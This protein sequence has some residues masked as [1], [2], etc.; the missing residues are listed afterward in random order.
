MPIVYSQELEDGYWFVGKADDISD[1]LFEKNEWTKTHEILNTDKIWN[2]YTNI[3]AI[4]KFYMA[5]Y[6][7]ERV[8]GGSYSSAVLSPEEINK[9]KR[10]LFPSSH[11]CKVIINKNFKNV[12]RDY[13]GFIGMK[14][15]CYECGNTISCQFKV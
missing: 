2:N 10:E 5:K 3:D 9:L 8:R 7:I 11:Q 1:A 6:G 13:G 14:T 4:V 15:K 12:F